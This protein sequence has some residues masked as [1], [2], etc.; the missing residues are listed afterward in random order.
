VIAVGSF[1]KQF[2]FISTAPCRKKIV[3]ESF[4]ERNLKKKVFENVFDI[5]NQK[6]KEGDLQEVV[7]GRR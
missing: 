1:K 6:G 4:F 5:R 3:V 2:P 7:R